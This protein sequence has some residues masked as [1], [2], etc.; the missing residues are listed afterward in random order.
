MKKVT[1]YSRPSIA[2]QIAKGHG[3]LEE[4]EAIYADLVK[5]GASAKTLKKLR[6]AIDNRVF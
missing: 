5:K 6:K 1:T 3:T 4:V 2:D